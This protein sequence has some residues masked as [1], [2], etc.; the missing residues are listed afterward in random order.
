MHFGKL[1]I[2]GICLVSIIIGGI[3]CAKVLIKPQYD[4][5][6]DTILEM[7]GVKRMTKD[8]FDN[9]GINSPKDVGFTED[10]KKIN[11][12]YG[13]QEFY[14]MKDTLN[15]D[16]MKEAM[17]LLKLEIKYDKDGNMLMYYKGVKTERFV[18]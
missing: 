2:I 5:S 9:L 6:L 12:T 10:D 1:S 16:R 13:K 17:K 14:I 3:I 8:V 4:P 18:K 7:D 11:V 15:E